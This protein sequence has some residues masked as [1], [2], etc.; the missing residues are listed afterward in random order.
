MPNLNNKDFAIHFL[1][2]T[3]NYAVLKIE[4]DQ[5]TNEKRYVPLISESKLNANMQSNIYL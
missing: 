5:P 4:I 1:T 3:T 2:P